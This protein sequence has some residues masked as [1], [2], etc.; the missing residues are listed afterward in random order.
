MNERL[1]GEV[2]EHCDECYLYLTPDDEEHLV[3]WKIVPRGFSFDIW[4]FDTQTNELTMEGSFLSKEKA[5][6][7]IYQS[8]LDLARAV[9]DLWAMAEN[10][11][12]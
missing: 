10:Y 9:E 7:I 8:S 6:S 3:Y 12:I 2:V 5:R 11:D 4:V 1:K